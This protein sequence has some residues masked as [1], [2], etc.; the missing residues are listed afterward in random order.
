MNPEMKTKLI[1][2][3]VLSTFSIDVH[4]EFKSL[5]S[6]SKR[7]RNHFNRIVDLN[8]DIY[9]DYLNKTYFDVNAVYNLNTNNNNLN[10]TNTNDMN[11]NVNEI[12][13]RMNN[14]I[15]SKNQY[16]STVI[17]KQP[18]KFERKTS[19]TFKPYDYRNVFYVNFQTQPPLLTTCNLLNYG[20]GN[21]QSIQSKI[22][23][24]FSRNT[25]ISVSFIDCGKFETESQCCY[26]LMKML[27][28]VYRSNIYSTNDFISSYQSTSVDDVYQLL[29]E[30]NINNL[31]VPKRNYV[32]IFNNVDCPFLIDHRPYFLDLLPKV[33]SMLPSDRFVLNTNTID[34]PY[35]FSLSEL[36]Q[37]KM[38][39]NS[40]LGESWK[41]DIAWFRE[42]TPIVHKQVKKKVIH[43]AKSKLKELDEID[44]NICC[45]IIEENALSQTK[46]YN[47]MRSSFN[48]PLTENTFKQHLQKMIEMGIITNVNGLVSLTVDK[49]TLYD[50]FQMV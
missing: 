7:D 3:S 29:S 12:F 42:Y 14:S 45:C 31:L 13:N 20:I 8:D 18:K 50:A 22:R 47:L 39:L 23:Q 48:H 6:Q 32:Y 36:I 9:N 46:L 21:K 41:Y 26:E 17:N 28:K 35:L 24:R 37:M 2:E 30:I 19:E 27:V 43:I 40:S 38:V 5:I 44:Q 34:G 10:N 11:N 4:P 25:N 1:N 49:E 16:E 15:Q 33:I